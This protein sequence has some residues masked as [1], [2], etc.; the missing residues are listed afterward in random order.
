MWP[1]IDGS[2]ASKA[3]DSRVDRRRNRGVGSPR[4]SPAGGTCLGRRTLASGV[5][6]TSGWKSSAWLG[7]GASRVG[8]GRPAGSGCGAWNRRRRGVVAHRWSFPL[9]SPATAAEG[10]PPDAGGLPTSAWRERIPLIRVRE[11]PADGGG[12]AARVAAAATGARRPSRRRTAA[13]ADC[14]SGTLR[15]QQHPGDDR[16]HDQAEHQ[17]SQQRAGAAPVSVSVSRPSSWSTTWAI[18]PAISD[19]AIVTRMV[20]TTCRPRAGRPAG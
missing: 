10:P 9:G 18:R 11:G 6:G 3:S 8:R 19:A 5:V 7:R 15:G 16:H 14:A 20:R 2:A 1:S 12:R 13:S 4:R 17:Q